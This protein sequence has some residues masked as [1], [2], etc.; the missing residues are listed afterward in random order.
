MN[1]KIK[2]PILRGFHPDPSIIRI[3][4]DYYIAASTFEWWPGIRLHH[5]R[6]LKNWELAGY[7]VSRTSQADLR[8]V[9]ASQGIWAPCLSFDDGVF[10]LVY[11]VVKAFYC[12]MYDTFNYLI[13]AEDIRGP[14]SEPVMLNNFGFDPSLFHKDFIK[15][16]LYIERHYDENL[17]L[18]VL[19]KEVHMNPYYFSS[20]FK[21]NAGENFKDYVSRVR[22]QHAVSLL[23]STDMKAYEIAMQ[24]GFSDARVF[25]ENFQRIYHETPKEY[26]KRAKQMKH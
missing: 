5:S 17:T 11:T 16:K 20:F 6:D 21:K 15:A 13:T 9:G 10:Y 19:A 1:H 12:N 2:N 3:G 22:V 8:G 4:E 14:W 26:R 25:S 18:E 24:T 7:L 23:V